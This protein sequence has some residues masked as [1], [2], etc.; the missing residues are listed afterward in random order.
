MSKLSY[1]LDCRSQRSDGTSTLKVMVNS[2]AGSF[3]VATDIY[4]TPSQWNQQS[5]VIVNHPNRVFLN[6][7]LADM[8][9]RTNEILM[10]AKIK[11]GRPLTREEM[12]QVVLSIFKG[13][14]VDYTS[15]RSVFERTI[16]DPTLS[17]R[18]H[19]LYACTLSKVENYIGR[20]ADKLRFEEITVGWL[21][22]FDKWLVGSCPAANARAIHMRNLRKVFNSAIDDDITSNYPFRKFKIRKEATRKRSLT[23]EQLRG[24]MTM[25][26]QPYQKRY[27]DTFILMFYMMG[28]NAV[29]LLSATPDMIV[30]GRLDYKR[31]K[32]GRN[33]SIKIEP[34]AQEIIDRYKGR[35]HLLKFCDNGRKYKNFLKRMNMCLKK[36]IPGCSSYYARH[37][38]ATIAAQID[39]PLD[40]IANM[41]GHTDTSRR[42]TLVYVDFNLKKVD[43]ANRKVIDYI[44][45]IKHEEENK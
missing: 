16:K 25:E 5:K 38:C 14:Y 45:G 37:S 22:N 32:T 8:L 10:E 11:N 19:E 9:R 29:D 41:L 40:T 15:V 28:I 42:V 33:Y 7:H 24:L 21:H 20:S 35:T 13:N 23:V 39:I 30:N 3:M 27:V 6:A 36:L 31:T 4:L 34:E 17:K 12:K 1:Y 43:D 18:T 44:L 2:T 26:L